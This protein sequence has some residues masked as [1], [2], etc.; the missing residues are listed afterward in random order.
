[1]LLD[2]SIPTNLGGGTE[3]VIIG[4]TADELHFWDEGVRFI[5]AEQPLAANLAV[6]L[7]LYGYSA[8]TAGRYPSAHGTVGGTGCAAPTF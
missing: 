3:D 6:R 4:V 1:V 5:R 8:F 7:V 2:G